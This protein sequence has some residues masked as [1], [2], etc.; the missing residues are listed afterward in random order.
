MFKFPEYLFISVLLRN[1]FLR[2]D[3]ENAGIMMDVDNELRL[4]D[5]EYYKRFMKMQD[6]EF[7][8]ILSMIVEDIMK[9]DTFMRK[10]IDARHR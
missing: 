7:E 8:Y 10:S 9:K 3:T 6:A 5:D 1:W 4:E 2:R